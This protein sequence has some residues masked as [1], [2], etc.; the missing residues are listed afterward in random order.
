MLGGSCVM[1]LDLPSIL[2]KG[3]TGASSEGTTKFNEQN[4]TNQVS[5]VAWSCDASMLASSSFDGTVLLFAWSTNGPQWRMKLSDN[6]SSVL[7]VAFHPQGQHLV[8]IDKDS[9]VIWN[10]KDGK[11]AWTWNLPF[12]QLT[13]HVDASGGLAATFHPAGRFLFVLMNDKMP[14][15]DVT[16]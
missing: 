15:L 2:Q 3:L 10:V 11:V 16:E 14:I 8:G 1:A 4:H 5:C 6:Q 13:A 9:V 12:S 7:S